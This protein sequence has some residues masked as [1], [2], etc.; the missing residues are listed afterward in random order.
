MVNSMSKLIEVK[1][2]VDGGKASSGP[3]LG[4]T[5]GP[6]RVNVKE[7]IAQINEKTKEFENMKV[8]VVVKVNPENRTFEIEVKTP[9]TSIL[10]IKEAGA[11]KGSGT[12]GTTSAGNIE[13]ANVIKVAN[14][15]K[16]SMFSKTFKNTVKEVVGT[17]L[18][19]GL[20]VDG[21]NPKDIIT[22]INS[23]KYDKV[24]SA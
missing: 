11:P 18:S 10:L 19:C 9:Q 1:A 3:P 7:V 15:K 14:M 5:L 22:D 13:M 21:K 2:L 8:P 20:T 6:L 4:S 17:C 23:G 16:D 24:I 12:A